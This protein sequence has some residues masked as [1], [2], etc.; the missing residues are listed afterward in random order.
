MNPAYKAIIGVII[1]DSLAKTGPIAANIIGIVV[2]SK[3]IG[4]I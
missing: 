2:G 4:Q 1:T 3:Y